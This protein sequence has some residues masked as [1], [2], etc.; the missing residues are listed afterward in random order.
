MIKY[1]VCDL[2]ESPAH[3]LGNTVNTGR[4]KR[5]C[6]ASDFKRMGLEIVSRV[7]HPLR[8][9]SLRHGSTLALPYGE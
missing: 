6:I 4:V 7:S 1:V 2:F 5:N 3:V 9:A 8:T